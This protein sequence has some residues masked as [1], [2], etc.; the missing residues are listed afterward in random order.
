MNM[1]FPRSRERIRLH[2][3]P[4]RIEKLASADGVAVSKN[5]HSRDLPFTSPD[6]FRLF[7]SQSKPLSRLDNLDRKEGEP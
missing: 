5:D 2:L 4:K 7:S 3:W 6:F 1:F